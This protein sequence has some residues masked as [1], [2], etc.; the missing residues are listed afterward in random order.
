[1]DPSNLYVPENDIIGQNINIKE[2]T[3]LGQAAL[4]FI[5]SGN[6]NTAVGYSALKNNQTGSHNIG[7]GAEA[8]FSNKSAHAN[9]A[10][11]YRTL[12]FNTS[13]ENNVALGNSAG[14]LEDRSK[15][16]GNTSGSQNVWIGN[17]AS[18][19]QG[20]FNN[21]VAIG[22]QANITRSN[23]VVLGNTRTE[24]TRLHGEISGFSKL[25]T[26]SGA[27]LVEIAQNT[28]NA[29]TLENTAFGV[30]A[31][32]LNTGIRNTAVGYKA[33]QNSTTGNHNTSV[34]S[35]ALFT[36]TSASANVAVGDFALYYNISGS[37]NVAIGQ[38]A[39]R[40]E[41]GGGESGNKTGSRNVWIG[42]GACSS[43]EDI[44]DSVAI[45][46]QAT[47]TRPNEVVL[48]G[49]NTR[50]TV[51]HGSVSGLTD[52]TFANGSNVPQFMTDAN[53]KFNILTIESTALKERFDK[54]RSEF[55]TLLEEVK[56]IKNELIETRKA[57][58]RLRKEFDEH[59]KHHS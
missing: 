46:F 20:D 18:S 13:G 31:L 11:G 16:A 4:T 52:L 26:P 21:S 2:D 40:R 14:R 28:K 29:N 41:P 37:E 10:V 1:M 3:A 49:A 19:S 17:D 9:V 38:F 51:L 58:G 23:E 32:K 55:D 33:L 25:T 30:N 48:G 59:I 15:K 53:T 45:G 24:F 6:S 57:L 50:F 43:N 27:D 34:G 54:L 5:T 44:N 42:C 12:Y 39:G 47:I 36:S 22:Y 7:I 56:D 35:Y 8:L